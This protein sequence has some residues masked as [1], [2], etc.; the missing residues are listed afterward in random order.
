MKDFIKSFRSINGITV[1]I[2]NLQVHNYV[3]A[4]YEE[5]IIETVMKMVEDKYIGNLLVS[6]KD[7]VKVEVT[8]KKKKEME[9]EELEDAFEHYEDFVEQIEEE[10]LT[11]DDNGEEED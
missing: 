10:E 3:P 5:R 7:G 1:T 11:G 8:E 9:K 6:D 2:G 4:D